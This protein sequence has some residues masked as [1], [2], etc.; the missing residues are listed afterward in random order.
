MK[1]LILASL[2]LFL[3]NA[4]AQEM[5]TE[6]WEHKPLVEGNR[7]IDEIIEWSK[8]HPGEIPPLTEEE[9][10]RYFI[11][12]GIP[13]PGEGAQVK[14]MKNIQANSKNG[15][16]GDHGAQIQKY[17]DAQKTDGYF[18][19]HSQQAQTLLSIPK[20][21]EK[22]LKEHYSPNLPAE[23]SHFRA[24]YYDI[25]MSYPYKSVASNLVQKVIGFAPQ[26]TYGPNGWNGAVE[27]FSPTFGDGVC[28]FHEVNIKIT[29]SSAYI[30]KEVATRDVND[31][32]TTVS[33]EGNEQSSY[34]YK[35]EWWD[36]TFMRSLEC[37]AKTYSDDL[38]QNVIELARAIDSGR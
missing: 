23:D 8:A 37:A 32:V 16:L 27:F 26:H 31:K 29:G 4:M 11:K 6:Y 12:D 15:L 5:K 34:I 10:Y 17:N 18:K 21:A 35:V 30:P 38:K 20:L 24:N 22:D 9:K 13:L 33:A 19:A 3:Q 25:K 7:R 36:K 28:A 1:K 14:S 2:V